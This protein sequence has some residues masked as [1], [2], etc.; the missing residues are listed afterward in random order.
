MSVVV[1][2]PQVAPVHRRP[3]H[4]RREDIERTTNHVR[5]EEVHLEAVLAV[6]LQAVDPEPVS[7]RGVIQRADRVLSEPD[8]PRRRFGSREVLSGRFGPF[9]QLEERPVD[10][11]ENCPIACRLLPNSG[12]TSA[13]FV[14]VAYAPTGGDTLLRNVLRLEK[15]NLARR[16]TEHHPVGR[17]RIQSGVRWRRVRVLLAN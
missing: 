2:V 15:S 7:V 13:E 10:S 14:S 11:H 3:A 16:A 9:G 17:V 12:R 8:P 4:R 1:A 5:A 6:M